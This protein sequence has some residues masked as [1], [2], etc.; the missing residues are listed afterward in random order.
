MLNSAIG[1][2]YL[3]PLVF[4][5]IARVISHSGLRLNYVGVG[6]T[7]SEVRLRDGVVIFLGGAVNI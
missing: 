6:S 7:G 4:I 2:C 5:A 3:C 1:C